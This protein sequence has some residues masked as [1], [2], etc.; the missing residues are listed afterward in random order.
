MT[1]VNVQ[2]EKV[3]AFRD[4]NPHKADQAVRDAKHL[5]SEALK[6]VRRSVGTLRSPPEFSLSQSLRD[7]VHNMNTEQFAIELKIEGDEAGFSRQSRL[8]LYRA[9][10]EGLT[11]IQKH[12]QANRVT[13]RLQLKSHEAQLWIVDNGQGFDPTILA[14][15]QLNGH[16]GLAG[17]RERLELINGSFELESN[18]AAGTSL[19]ITVPK[20]PLTLVSGQAR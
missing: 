14:G 17:V 8:T 11:N 6:D 9:A 2:L 16:Y 18:L 3:M 5:A 1:V 7:L 13:I 20:N 4:R 19:L 15:S 12:A 10:Q